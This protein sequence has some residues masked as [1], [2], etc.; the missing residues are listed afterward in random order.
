MFWKYEWGVEIIS[1]FGIFDVC[2]VVVFFK[3]GVD[4]KI[5]LKLLDFEGRYIIF[6]VEI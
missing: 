3:R 2:G 5:Y 6:K 1:V 4:Y